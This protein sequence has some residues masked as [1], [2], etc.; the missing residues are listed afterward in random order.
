MP[1]RFRHV[2][3]LGAAM[4][5]GAL[6]G[7]LIG[8]VTGLSSDDLSAPV[9]RPFAYAAVGVA[10][11][12]LFA[13]TTGASQALERGRREAAA[14]EID[15]ERLRREAHQG[16]IDGIDLSL[17]ARVDEVEG[18]DQA[19]QLERPSRRSGRTHH[20]ELSP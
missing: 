9:L 10:V 20:D 1:V 13:A 4:L 7:F 16:W 11:G 2:D 5:I 19:E 8:A 17:V 15:H 18:A 14:R 6:A 3:R 12:A